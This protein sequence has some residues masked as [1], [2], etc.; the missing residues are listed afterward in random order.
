MKQGLAFGDHIKTEKIKHRRNDRYFR[1]SPRGILLLC[2]LGIVIIILLYKVISLQL[3]KGGYYRKLSDSNR[4]RNLVIHAPRGVIFD[5]NG[6]PLVFNLPG[7][8]Q[9]TIDAHTGQ[10]KKTV[11]LSKEQAVMQLSKGAKN[12][13][14]DSLRQYP[15]KDQLAHVIG[16]IGQIS[17]TEL[18]NPDFSDY[19]PDDWVGKDGIEQTYEHQLRGKDGRQL[20]EVDAM[21]KLVRA[22]GKTDPSPGQDVR[23]TID[24]KLQQAAYDATQDVKAGAVIVSKPDGEVLAMVSRPSYDPNLF[25]LDPSYKVSSD[26][27]YKTVQ[28]ILTDNTG[29]PLLN[30]AI[31]G[32][33]PPGS[34]FKIVAA[35]AGLQDK[36]IDDN[37]SVTDTGVLTVGK[38][39]FANWLFTEYG[40]KETGGVNVVRALARSNDIFFYKLAELL[41][42]PRLSEMARS[43]GLGKT[44]G[45]DLAGEAKGVVPTKDWKQSNIKEPW[46][47]GDTYQYG[48]GQGYLLTTPLQVNAWTQVI[49][50][51]GDL[52]QPRLNLN[53]EPKILHQAFLSKKT[54]ETVREGM[55]GACNP[56]GVAYPLYNF[57]VTNPKLHIDGKDFYAPSASTSAQKGAVGVSIACKTGTAQHG[58][59][60]TLPHAWITLF[61]PAYNPQIVVTVLVESGGEGSTIAAPIAQKILEAYF[62]GK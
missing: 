36:V 10:V 40:K 59:D 61:A 27:A 13:A 31:A 18:S 54:V 23:L 46:Y 53:Q 16:Y 34:T 43:F 20:V 21:G 29:Q 17:Q 56:G 50:N 22:L 1:Y 12:I 9:V 35:A 48:I 62:G 19:Q 45:I 41:D 3:F 7:F 32:T 55:V 38:F 11:H 4:I 47:L 49:A 28:S 57:Q 60:Q 15:Y 51:G 44:L 14:V 30:R 42:I 52:Y 37:F 58:N 8:K 2:F 6:I 26:S 5:R 25:T 39:S 33:Y 24:E